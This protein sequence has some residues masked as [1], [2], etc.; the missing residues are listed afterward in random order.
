[1]KRKQYSTTN[2]DSPIEEIL[3]RRT[4]LKSARRSHFLV[5]ETLSRILFHSLPVRRRS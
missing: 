2:G 4:P 5:I 1:M 3:T